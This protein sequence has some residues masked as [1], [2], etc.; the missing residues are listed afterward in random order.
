[1]GPHLGR[2]E[3]VSPRRAVVIAMWVVAGVVLLLT[4]RWFLR[5]GSDE[6]VSADAALVFVG[7]ELER[8]RAV[9]DLAVDG[10]VDH[11]VVVAAG[12]GPSNVF[13]RMCE[14]GLRADVEL[15]C[16]E[17]AGADTRREAELLAEYATE[18]R[19]DH[20]VVVTSSYHLRRA[21]LLVERCFDGRVDQIAA[22]PESSAAVWFGQVLHEWGGILE[23]TLRRGC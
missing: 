19:W 5:P 23:T 2:R 21:T 4:D 18:Q 20:V 17:L 1:M 11:V 3:G 9:R 15:H 10:V 6:V 16:L 22:I 13:G 7:G 14:D 12:L 8:A